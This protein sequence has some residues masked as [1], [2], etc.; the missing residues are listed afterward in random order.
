MSML[1]PWQF[2]LLGG[3]DVV[4]GNFSDHLSFIIAELHDLFI[5]DSA[6][7]VPGQAHAFLSDVVRLLVQAFEVFVDLVTI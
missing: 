3:F 2:G 1:E 6:S 4:F 7:H 5:G